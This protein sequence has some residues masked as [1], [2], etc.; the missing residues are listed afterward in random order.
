MR[1]DTLCRFASWRQQTAGA[2]A[3]LAWFG[4]TLGAAQAQTL[5]ADSSRAQTLKCL[6][7]TGDAPAFPPE[8]LEARSSGF[9][10]IKLSFTAQDK[11]PEM[12]V[13][14]RAGSA[15]H[16]AA[17]EGFVRSYRLPCLKPGERLEAVQEFKFTAIDFGEVSWK[18]AHPLNPDSRRKSDECL[19][20]PERSLRLPPQAG[21]AGGIKH[22]SSGTVI[23]VAEFTQAGAPAAVQVLYSSGYRALEMA[24]TDYLGAYRWN[25]PWDSDRPQKIQQQFT[26]RDSEQPRYFF[27]EPNVVK[28]LNQVKDI[29]KQRV[30]FD[31]D[32]MACPFDVVLRV[33]QP[34]SKN[35]V[36]QVGPSNLNRAEFLSWLETLSLDVSSAVF[37]QVLGQ[38]IKIHV[39]CGTIKLGD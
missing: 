17:V 36:G 23:A 3:A 9:Y 6:T 2:L 25:C 12:Q 22:K 31:L 8:E 35:E 28:F 24:V 30:N 1:I 26:F 33:Y 19:A 16:E 20:T 4:L 34:V 37:E 29:E 38:T 18:D 27:G 7:K 5:M 32:T 21:F 10:R 15:R 14:F 39:P 13:I 11:A